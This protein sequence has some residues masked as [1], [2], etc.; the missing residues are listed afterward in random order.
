MHL[1]LN[2]TTSQ[3]GTMKL[4]F[5]YPANALSIP[6]REWDHMGIIS[7]ASATSLAQANMGGT[8]ITITVYAWADNIKLSAPT[9]SN[10]GALSPQANEAEEMSS[11]PIS[12][13]ANVVANVAG[14]LK[15]VPPLSGLATTTEAAAKMVASTAQALGFSKPA[16]LAPI[17][18]MVPH[19]Q[20]NMTNS[21][22]IDTSVKL[23]YDAKAETTIDSAAVGVRT[24]PDEMNLLKMAQHESYISQFAWDVNAANNTLLWNTYV[25]PTCSQIIGNYPGRQICMPAIAGVAF[26]FTFWRGTIK[27]R[28]QV[29]GNVFHRGRL[30]I[31]WDPYPTKGKSETNV[32]YTHIVDIGETKD[33]TIDVG[34]G[35][36]T[37]YNTVGKTLA[38]V[39]ITTPITSE[40]LGSA[41]GILQV[42]VNNQLTVPYTAD[43]IKILVSV[44][45][46]DDFEVAVPATDKLH[47]YSYFSPSGPPD[48]VMPS[49]LIPEEE[50]PVPADQP[51]DPTPPLEPLEQQ[52]NEVEDNTP[53]G[54]APEKAGEAPLEHF[55][56]PTQPSNAFQ[57]VHFGDPVMSLRQILKRYEHYCSDNWA[58][59]SIL[60][61]MVKV[62]TILPRPRGYCDVLESMDTEATGKAF[63]YTI[64]GAFTWFLPMFLAM[65]GGIRRKFMYD[66]P[67]LFTLASVSRESDPDADV[68]RVAINTADEADDTMMS[69]TCTGRV[70]PL[71]N[72]GVAQDLDVSRTMEVE[73]PFHS[74]YR[75]F[76]PRRLAQR[77]KL[78][79]WDNPKYLLTA[80]SSNRMNCIHEFIAAGDD[81]SLHWFQGMPMLY[82]YPNPAP[83]VKSQATS[84]LEET[85]T[86]G[87]PS[88]TV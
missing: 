60:R 34:W 81:L 6:K 70:G 41:N 54:S 76:V 19:S 45:A 74:N 57:M 17:N 25:H 43:P 48:I 24:A 47:E 40:M 22:T 77:S 38:P 37:A 53:E 68:V 12:G 4:P 23:T 27:Y 39:G 83:I 2:P 56:P 28:F 59:K 29:V 36:G 73:F 35:S 52:A 85:T 50:E 72:G 1:W 62:D 26:P 10:V 58:D 78:G 9:M 82:E 63:N 31:S 75:F 30:K 16:S 65:R 11:K 44:S 14:A 33:F 79:T 3:G 55:G 84:A 49:N 15:S 64:N 80:P 46:G 71:S 21:N 42:H 5:V 8:P 69:Y 87:D 66:G 7:F 67:L 61:T 51:A 32:Q 20:G 13:P 88:V 86:T 18:K